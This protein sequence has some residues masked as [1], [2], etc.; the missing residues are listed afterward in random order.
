MNPPPDNIVSAASRITGPNHEHRTVWLICGQNCQ[1]A[2]FQHQSRSV[3]LGTPSLRT[4]TSQS[5]GSN[6]EIVEARIVDQTLLAT[7][8]PCIVNDEGQFDDLSR[9]D[10]SSGFH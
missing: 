5:N 10:I 2:K 3:E 8:V 6:Q 7:T 9:F 4:R 1:A